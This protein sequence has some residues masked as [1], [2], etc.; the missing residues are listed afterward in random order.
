MIFSKENSSLVVSTAIKN[1]L[2]IDKAL[3]AYLT[4]G[5]DIFVLFHILEGQVVQFPSKRRLLNS[6]LHN[7]QFIED[8]DRIYADYEKNDSIEYK[9]EFYSVIST[10]KKILNHYYI[11]VIKSSERTYAE[12]DE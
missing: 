2:D 7:I 1:N 3:A 8:D 5:N 10:E 11:P 6:T 4:V 9:G 12:T